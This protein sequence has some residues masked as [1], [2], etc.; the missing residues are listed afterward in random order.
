MVPNSAIFSQ[1]SWFSLQ[2]HLKTVLSNSLRCL[3]K[4][5]S[6]HIP[7]LSSQQYASDTHRE[8]EYGEGAS[9]QLEHIQPIEYEEFCID[10]LSDVQMKS[11]SVFSPKLTC[12]QQE[13]LQPEQKYEMIADK[14]GDERSGMQQQPGI[15]GQR[16]G[17]QERKEL[18]SPRSTAKK[19]V[20]DFGGSQGHGGQIGLSFKREGEQTTRNLSKGASEESANRG[21]D[22]LKQ[23]AGLVIEESNIDEQ[24]KQKDDEIDFLKARIKYLEEK[25]GEKAESHRSKHESTKCDKETLTVDF[26]DPLKE[27]LEKENE[28]FK[29]E[30][31][32]LHS[33]LRELQELNASLEKKIELQVNCCN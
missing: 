17:A 4:S 27:K 9:R 10:R 16:E 12:S 18:P 20:F 15:M 13:L 1:N 8:S 6:K 31:K 11:V 28:K 30:S 29:L 22:Q 24:L 32:Q 7:S 23:V 5:N 21:N 19:F 25:R 26:A 3:G 14:K 2:T 33:K